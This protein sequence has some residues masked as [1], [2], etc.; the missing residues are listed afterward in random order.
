MH[1]RRKMLRFPQPTEFVAQYVW[2]SPIGAALGDSDPSMLEP[3]VREVAQALAAYVDDR[4]L[5]FPIENHLA[6]AVRPSPAAD[7]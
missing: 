2:G 7:H 1:S 4:V 6:L 5:S 3:V